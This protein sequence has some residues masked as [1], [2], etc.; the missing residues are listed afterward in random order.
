MPEIPSGLAH[1]PDGRR[2]EALRGVSV[3][4]T[5]KTFYC[6]PFNKRRGVYNAYNQIT[7]QHVVPSM[8][9]KGMVAVHNPHFTFHP[10]GIFQLKASDTRKGEFLFRGIARPEITLLNHAEFPWIRAATPPL[11]KM[12]SGNLRDQRIEVELLTLES[13]TENASV[14]IGIDFVMPGRRATGPYDVQ[15]EFEWGGLPLSIGMQLAQRQR[16]V[17]SWFHVA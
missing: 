1:E 13:D 8:S 4:L 15:W 10:P 3:G 14:G 16:A 11:D 5:D 2:G 7:M 12:P 6:P 17:L 9:R